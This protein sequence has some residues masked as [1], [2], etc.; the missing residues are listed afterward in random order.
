MTKPNW[1]DTKHTKTMEKATAEQV[2][3]EIAKDTRIIQAVKTS[4]ADH[5]SHAGQK[6]GAGPSR[7]QTVRTAISEVLQEA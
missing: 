4:L 3:A 1:F 2:L 5:D 7:T 6:G